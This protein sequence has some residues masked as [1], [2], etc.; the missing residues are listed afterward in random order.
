MKL[1][2]L[3]IWGGYIK[4]PLLKFI[5][6]HQ[7]I[8]IFCFQE[9][10]H[11]APNK[12]STDDKENSL[13]IF[14]ELQDLLPEHNAFFRPVVSNIFGIGMLI[15]K[16]VNVLGEGEITIHDNPS[17]TG[18]GPEHPRNLQ[19]M[20]CSINNQIYSIFNV[21]GLWNGKGK[22]DTPERIMQSKRIKDFIDTVNTPKILCG[23]FN[24]KPDTESMKI[25]EHNMSN[26][27]ILHNIT[28]TRSSL[29]LKEERFADY[30]FT[31]NEI[32]VKKFEVLKDVVSDHLALLLE[33]D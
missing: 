7:D 25:L 9:V 5:A 1:I 2:T 27:V 14:S 19:W 29:Y 10:S 4:E 23:D 13:N 20:E 24:L 31:S 3:N 26:L 15:K 32:N 21:H 18:R 30:I 16:E 28:S 22:T 33:F 6:T 11:N 12:I 8:D 17:Y